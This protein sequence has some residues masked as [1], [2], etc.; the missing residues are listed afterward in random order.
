MLMNAELLRID[1][2][3]E[4]NVRESRAW[5]TRFAKWLTRVSHFRFYYELPYGKL[6]I[7]SQLKRRTEFPAAE[8]LSRGIEP[9]QVLPVVTVM[10]TELHLPNHYLL[11]DDPLAAVLIP[12]DDDFPLDWLCHALRES[13]GVAGLPWDI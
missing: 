12:D 2:Q 3:F 4:E 9:D 5:Y 7:E 1:P 10:A 8:W 13:I 6:S 11:P